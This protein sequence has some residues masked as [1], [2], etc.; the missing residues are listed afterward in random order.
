LQDSTTVVASTPFIQKREHPRWKRA[1]DLAGVIVVLP[2][3]SPLLALVAL[4]IKAV[5]P[6]PVLFVQSR[7]GHGGGDFRIIKFRTM[8]VPKT[9]RDETHRGY[10]A[11]RV[12][13]GQPIQK[14]HFLRNEL[15][16]GGAVL[17]K[18]SIDE[19]PQLFNVV[20]GSM[21]LVGPRPD[22]LRLDDYE[23]WHLRRFEVLPG[24]TGLWQV[25]GKNRLTHDQMVELDIEYIE[26]RSLRR[27]LRILAKTVVVVLLGG[28]E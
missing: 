22:V 17:R 11:S 27:D 9:C 19:F 5:S 13:T 1:L 10:V 26:T 3:L 21:S 18:W 25:S 23:P 16:P 6:G 24:M 28:G 8:H 2:V 15:I 14:P 7:V 12:C 4:Y 20:N